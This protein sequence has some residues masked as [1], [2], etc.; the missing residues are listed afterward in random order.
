VTWVEDKQDLPAYRMLQLLQFKSVE[1][2]NLHRIEASNRVTAGKLC[3][4]TATRHAIENSRKRAGW[5]VLANVTEDVFICTHGNGQVRRVFWE[6]R[7]CDCGSWQQRGIPCEH[8]AAVLG[9]AV[10]RASKQPSV[11]LL[12]LVNERFH[13]AT[14]LMTFQYPYEIVPSETLWP[15]QMADEQLLRA[16]PLTHGVRVLPKRKET[17]IETEEGDLTIDGMTE[18]EAHQA[19]NSAIKSAHKRQRSAANAQES[20]GRSRM[21]SKKVRLSQSSMY[22]REILSPSPEEAPE[23]SRMPKKMKSTPHPHSALPQSSSSNR[24]D[25]VKY[26]PGRNCKESNPLSQVQQ[27]PITTHAKKKPGPPKGWKQARALAEAERA[28]AAAH[29]EGVPQSPSTG[30]TNTA[31]GTSGHTQRIGKIRLVDSMTLLDSA[32]AP[33]AEALDATHTKRLPGRPPGPAL[34]AKRAAIA[35]ENADRIA[36][37]LP[38]LEDESRPKPKTP[39]KPSRK[40][41]RRGRP[42]G[43][44]AKPAQQSSHVRNQQNGQSSQGRAVNNPHYSVHN[45]SPFDFQVQDSNVRGEMH[46]QIPQANKKVTTSHSAEEASVDEQEESEDDDEDASNSWRGSELPDGPSDEDDEESDFDDAAGTNGKQKTPKAKDASHYSNGKSGSA[47]DAPNRPNSA[48][49]DHGD[50]VKHGKGMFR[51]YEL[52]TEV[53]NPP[54]KSLVTDI[55][56]EPGKARATRQHRVKSADPIINDKM[57]QSKEAEATKEPTV[58]TETSGDNGTRQEAVASDALQNNQTV[59]AELDVED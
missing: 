17:Y 14:W 13:A 2:L 33:H 31:S 6:E 12:L 26:G 52:I 48:T 25:I 42:S 41:K 32:P 38:P 47:K 18:T 51:R 4:E 35:K 50:Q 46:T 23:E 10:F 22:D 49:D 37:G 53:R 39:S 1:A 28:K 16:P 56:P 30:A 57:S 20:E 5:A 29:A 8:A 44:P 7:R 58:V 36:A 59:A 55:E 3:T 27:S 34:L 9:S 19:L 24:N 43:P 11:D 45:A 40:K 54:W 21:P 15:L